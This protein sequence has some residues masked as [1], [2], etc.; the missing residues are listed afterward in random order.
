MRVRSLV[1]LGATVAVMAGIAATYGLRGDKGSGL[2]CVWSPD[3]A[4]AYLVNVN[5][6]GTFHEGF[7]SADTSIPP[8][9][10]SLSY[11]A[12]INVRAATGGD[13][14]NAYN[15]KL[16][17][18]DG[19][20]E[21]EASLRADL[22]KSFAFDLGDDCRFGEFG[23]A[24]DEGRESRDL[25]KSL[26]LVLEA[27]AR[28]KEK[29]D[30]TTWMAKQSDASGDFEARYILNEST[31]QIIRTR[32][33]YSKTTALAGA[34]PLKAEIAR[35]EGTFDAS[36]RFWL[37][38][39]AVRESVRIVSDKNESVVQSAAAVSLETTEAGAAFD[40]TTLASMAWEPTRIDQSIKFTPSTYD[41][42]GSTDLASTARTLTEAMEAFTKGDL[43]GGKIDREAVGNMV[44]FLR[45]HPEAIPQLLD[46]IKA[47][48]VDQRLHSVLFFTL[49]KV[50]TPEVQRALANVMNDVEHSEANRMQAIHALADVAKPLPESVD[51]IIEMAKTFEPDG[52]NNLES[53]AL[54]ALGVVERQQLNGE[55]RELGKRAADVLLE[56]MKRE[57]AGDYEKAVLVDALGNTG[58]P[59]HA[60]TIIDQFNDDAPVVRVSAAR[61]LARMDLPNTEQ[62][63]LDAMSRETV[64]DSRR[65]I[66]SAWATKGGQVGVYDTGKLIEMLG[67]EREESVKLSMIAVLGREAATQPAIKSALVNQYEKE[68][69]TKV[70]YAIGKYLSADDISK[71]SAGH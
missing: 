65:E 33:Y 11:R 39:A 44:H 4:A 16:E 61:A 50:G 45:A 60:Q 23:F 54:L 26:F 57:D 27:I 71:G 32:L 48:E 28:P 56:K 55:A 13:R 40:A 8:R 21:R 6:T 68:T 24:S 1:F 20:S 69:S 5:S 34:I 63:L 35:S 42:I 22:A 14:P 18:L 46:S 31:G 58:N 2:R 53:T 36:S 10:I 51:A 30:A 12:R 62:A 17:L 15:A 41:H 43:Y 38:K 47:G 29:A 66:A 3:N 70:K 19:F 7:L 25:K 52:E 59:Q 37:D 64:A 49:T 9:Q 67:K